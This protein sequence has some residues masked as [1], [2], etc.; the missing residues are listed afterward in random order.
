MPATCNVRLLGQR[1]ARLVIAG[2]LATAAIGGFHEPPARADEAAGLQRGVRVA[3]L[4]SGEP[5]AFTFSPSLPARPQAIVTDLKVLLAQ[6]GQ[7]VRSDAVV[8]DILVAVTTST[9]LAVDEDI[10]KQHGLELIERTELSSLGLRVVR[11]RV[12]VS[13]A[14]GKVLA[15]LANDQRIRRAQ[16]DVEYQP[17]PPSAPAPVA[18]AT[19]QAPPAAAKADDKLQTTERRR[20]EAAK[21]AKAGALD[22]ADGATSYRPS[23]V[24]DVLSGGL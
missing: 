4:G 9:P 14:A 6:N 16:M 13:V 8:D 19:K 21:V 20:I 18:S 24:G 17:L 5:E 11:Y 7:P 2:A 1:P 22:K 3:A 12:P 23:R 15:A 10:A